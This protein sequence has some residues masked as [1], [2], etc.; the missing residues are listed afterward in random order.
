ML[1]TAITLAR[2]A[3]AAEPG[4]TFVYI[5]ASSA[6]PLL[7]RRYISTKREA[8]AAIAREF[9]SMRPVF[10]RPSFM[11]DASRSFTLPVAAA[12]MAGNMVNSAV[13]GRLSW[14]MGSGGEK[15]LKVESVGDAVVE[16]IEDEEVRGVVEIGEI[17]R[18]ATK[19]WR[20][21][22]L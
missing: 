22:M 8:E 19:A 6:P 21:G 9:P 7:P 16:A 2:E 17:E 1:L 15:P 11:F 12:A 18:L 14:L 20:R 5:S 13:G 4:T 10:M 3:H